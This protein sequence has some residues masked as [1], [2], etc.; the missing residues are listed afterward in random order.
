MAELPEGLTIH[1]WGGIKS[2][3]QSIHWVLNFFGQGGKYSIK[4]DQ[5]Y[6][7]TP[8][9]AALAHKSSLG[10]LPYM[11]DSETGARIGQ[12]VAIINYCAKKFGFEASDLKDYATS[13]ELLI[14]SAEIHGILGKAHYAPDG[15]RAGAFDVLFGGDSQLDKY[16]KA[17]ES[18]IGE[19]GATCTEISPGDVA[20][21]AYCGIIEQLEAG[22]IE[23]SGYAKSLAL[24]TKVLENA[25][26]TKYEA[27]VPYPYFKRQNDS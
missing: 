24:Y 18:K 2:R 14:M 21:A 16:F 20:F 15:N 12:T 7:G 5:P 10:Q 13:Q 11:T 23:K 9:F 1:Y 4:N 27:T 3:G 25:D 26:V 22:W 6:P 8:E 17:V 19:S